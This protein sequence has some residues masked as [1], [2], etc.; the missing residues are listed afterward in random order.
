MPPPERPG[1]YREVT[2]LLRPGG[3]LYVFEHNPWNPVAQWV[4]RHTPI[5]RD[6]VLLGA[7]RGA[8]AADLRYRR[9][10]DPL[11]DV[12]SAGLDLGQ[13]WRMASAGFPWAVST[14]SAG[15]SR[16]HKRDTRPWCRRLAE[17]RAARLCVRRPADYGKMCGS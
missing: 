15:K 7:R 11:P 4:V 1:L 5:D 14:S 8:L 9:G 17:R 3:R 6:A 12:L 16:W 10:Q 2:R 13:A